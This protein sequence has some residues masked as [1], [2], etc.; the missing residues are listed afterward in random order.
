[1]D[2]VVVVVVV[3]D[4]GPCGAKQYVCENGRCIDLNARC[5]G[6]NDCSDNSDEQNCGTF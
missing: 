6:K 5:D 4:E 1:M 3:V 2:V